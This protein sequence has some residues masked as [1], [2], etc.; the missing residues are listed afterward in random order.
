MAPAKSAGL[1]RFGA[2]SSIEICENLFIRFAQPDERLFVTPTIGMRGPQLGTE[3]R[4]DLIAATVPGDAES[5]VGIHG[6]EEFN[7]QS[8]SHLSGYQS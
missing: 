8:T 2:P 1:G 6:G 5:F 4:L 7:S 3:G